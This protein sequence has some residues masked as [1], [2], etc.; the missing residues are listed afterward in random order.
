[1]PHLLSAI[2]AAIP[3]AAIAC[4]VA[5]LFTAGFMVG[6]VACLAV[7]FEQNGDRETKNR[8]PRLPE[9]SGPPQNRDDNPF[10]K[11]PRPQPT[12]VQS[13]GVPHVANG[14]KYL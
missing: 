7:A 5:A 12:G 14:G 9:P 8:P 4:A 13:T 11:R 1:M 2:W 10:Y 6:F 3:W